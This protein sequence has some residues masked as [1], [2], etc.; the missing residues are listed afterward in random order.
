MSLTRLVSAAALVAAVV[1]LTAS[2]AA[3][4]TPAQK[5]AA[6][7]I[8][9]ALIELKAVDA[10][11]RHGLTT[12]SP[13]DPACLAAAAAKLD[14]A[15]RKADAQ[16]GCVKTNDTAAID[17][18]VGQCSS[19]LVFATPPVCLTAGTACSGSLAAP[20]CAGLVCSAVIG[21]PPPACH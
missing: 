13:P 19:R 18:A 15:V 16:G 20:C 11:Y 21:G 12:L 9:A 4:A 1:T 8:K 3:A 10:C 17:Q 6:A 2:S 7:K 14:A 5:C